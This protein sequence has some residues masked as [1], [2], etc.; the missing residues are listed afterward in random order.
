MLNRANLHYATARLLN[1]AVRPAALTAVAYFFGKTPAE[2]LSLIIFTVAIGMMFMSIDPHRAYYKKFFNSLPS[3]N[4]FAIYIII[5]SSWMLLVSVAIVIILSLQNVPPLICALSVAMFAGEKFADE[6]LRFRIFD[7]DLDSWSRLVMRRSLLQL[8][9]LAICVALLGMDI[10]FNLFLLAFS[11]SW[12]IA[13]FEPIF[14]VGHIIGRHLPSFTS[15]K[16]FRSAGR[17]FSGSATLMLSSFIASA[18]TYFDRMITVI[19]DKSSLPLFLIASM[20]F[21]I[22]TSFVDFFF[23]SRIRVNLLRNDVALKDILLRG[24]LWLCILAGIVAGVVIIAFE[25]LVLGHIYTFDYP[26]LTLIAVTNVLLALV[27]IPQQ[28]VY[29]RDGPRGIFAVEIPFLAVTGAIFLFRWGDGWTL[30]GALA[31]IAAG[32]FFRFLL[33][34]GRVRYGSV[35]AMSATAADGAASSP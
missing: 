2:E 17:R 29:W 23:V 13:F 12:V 31:V 15:A 21:A 28:I 18:P 33:Y 27:A 30:A 24:S 35:P 6:L 16:I 25:K 22:I 19:V 1:M 34:L 32:L 8:A 20:S 14:R 7:R 9:G 10:S 4:D 26:V 11:L 3:A 5:L